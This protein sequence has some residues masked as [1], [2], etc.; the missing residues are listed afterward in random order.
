MD[1]L[2]EVEE[3]SYHPV[4]E[5]I[6][7]LLRKM[8]QN[9]ESDHYFR[10]LAVF[11]QAQMASTMRAQVHTEDR[12]LL[13]INVY[14]LL[15]APSGFGK[16][17]SMN[18][19][20]RS[21]LHGF[22]DVF[23]EET[24]PE[25]V[26]QKIENEA[27][28][29]ANANGSDFEEE[30]ELLETEYGSYGAYVFAFPEG[31]GPAYRQVRAKCQMAGIG[32]TNFIADEIGYNLLKS[33]ELLDIHFE[34]YDAGLIKDKITK[35]SSENK[36]Y[37]QRH[38]PVPANLLA[39][40]TPDKLFDGG[41]TEKELLARLDSGYA[42]RF[43]YA[44]GVAGDAENISAEELYDRLVQGNSSQDIEALV[45]LFTNLADPIN[46]NQIYRLERPEGILLTAYRM[47]CTHLAA[48]IPEHLGMR[49]A[50]LQHRYFRALK[51]AG[52]YAFLDSAANITREHLLAAIK[53]VEDSGKAF[54][55]VITRPKAHV[56]LAQYIASVG[57]EVTHADL[58][59][60]LAF[61]PSA[62]NKQEEMLTLATAWGY[63]NHHIIRR[64][65]LDGIE[66]FSGETLKEVDLSCMRISHSYHEAY[67]Y[68]NITAS[69][70]ELQT[71][72][73]TENLSMVNH[74]LVDKHRTDNTVISG[75]DFIVLDCDGGVS[76][77]QFSIY[78]KGTLVH[79]YTTKRHT[80]EQNRFRAIIPLKYQLN[81]SKEDY[82]EFMNNIRNSL[83]FDIDE[84]SCS[85]SKKWLCHAGAAGNIDGELFDPIPYLPNTKKNEERIA[86]D[87]KLSNL[88]KVQKFFAKE[89]HTG[90][91]NTLLKYALML[92]D[93]G[94]SLHNA[95]ES[96]RKFNS[97]FSDPLEEAE[98]NDSVLKTLAKKANQ[99]E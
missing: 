17:K 2:K 92:L 73:Q 35:N 59:D 65:L 74:H 18:I 39:F 91:N 44:T 7:R 41:A 10:T 5:R 99:K 16:T 25:V 49:K 40:G 45:Q 93:S 23:A 66:F 27:Y 34:V 52:T 51:I 76:L 32:S 81:L 15:T 42:R 30:K 14:A 90:R 47:H 96:V 75:V 55:K 83:P 37:K 20:E 54:D 21:L 4:G 98:L 57:E 11:Y 71:L 63:R 60:Q 62:R 33:T 50:E 19:L 58:V 22:Y 8:N 86:Q 12:G 82:K 26:K 46:L 97:S 70:E 94:V 48:G 56:R 43:I 69:W 67:N 95:I 78:M 24:L 1:L 31:S 3:A 64:T 84:G 85:R 6:V 9:T 28:R 80:A 79:V 13:P 29:N 53:V 38:T 89:W 88:D 36:R 68:N 61:Y 77:K 72:F 87:A